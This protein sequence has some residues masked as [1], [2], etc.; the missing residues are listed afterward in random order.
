VHGKAACWFDAYGADRLFELE[1]LALTV[2]DAF[3]HSVFFTNRLVFEKEHWWNRLL[4]SETPLAMQR[5][6]NLHGL[7][8][9]ILPVTLHENARGGGV[10][11]S[12]A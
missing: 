1:K 12:A 2:R 11:A 3:P 4:H 9:V 7:E 6:L 10:V 5:L 8:L